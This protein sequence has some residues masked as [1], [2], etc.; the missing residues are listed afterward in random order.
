[1]TEIPFEDWKKLDLRVGTILEVNDHPS[2]DKLYVLKID[3]GSE[4]RTVVAGIKGFYSKDALRGKQVVVFTNL[5]QRVIRGIKSEG[6]ILAATMG[7][8]KVVLLQPEEKIENGAS[9]S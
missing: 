9:I 1:M 3:V 6:M 5:Q 4:V 7:E 2:A 8:E